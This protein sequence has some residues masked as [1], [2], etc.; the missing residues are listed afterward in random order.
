MR[1]DLKELQTKVADGSIGPSTLRNMGPRG[2]VRSAREFLSE[3]NLKQFSV[4]KSIFEKRLDSE[5]EK[6]KEKFPKG[7]RYWGPARKA[8]NIFL[9]DALKNRT[10]RDHYKLN[11]IENYL[12]IP[13][14]RYSAEGIG[15]DFFHWRG[16]IRV[17]RKINKVY[18]DI[19]LYIAE[20]KYKRP[21]VDLDLIYRERG[22]RK[23]NRSL[24]KSS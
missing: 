18:Q 3:L 1:K 21:R 8:I 13:L 14:D 15:E 5:T 23:K 22:K 10:L 24:E 2:M 17:E 9:R 11:R 19:A 12:E 7:G 6:L 20:H 4:R 16:V